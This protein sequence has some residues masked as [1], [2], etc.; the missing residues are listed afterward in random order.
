[1]DLILSFQKVANARAN[2]QT[3]NFIHGI[4]QMTGFAGTGKGGMA[5]IDGEKVVNAFVLCRVNEECS[6]NC[7]YWDDCASAKKCTK[8][9]ATDVYSLLKEQEEQIKNRDESLE[10]AREEIKWLRRMLN[11]YTD[12]R[13]AYIC[14]P[15]KNTSCTKEGCMIFQCCR[16]TTNKEFAKTGE[17]NKPIVAVRSDL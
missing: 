8:K 3:M 1:M 11:H 12:R 16:C 6:A 10:K 4:Q 13:P 5:M 17:N 2:V 9:L 15:E 14:D 7:S